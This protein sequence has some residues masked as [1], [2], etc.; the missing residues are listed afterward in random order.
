MTI[1]Q[2]IPR[3]AYERLSYLLVTATISLLLLSCNHADDWQ[4][5]IH[6]GDS[7]VEARSILGSRTPCDFPLDACEAFPNS[8]IEVKYDGDQVSEIMVF[9]DS[10]EERW[11][12]YESP[13]IFGITMRDG[14]P[15]LLDKLGEPTV[16][17]PEGFAMFKWRRPPWFVEVFFD[18]G[19]TGEGK[20]M[21]ITLTNAV[22]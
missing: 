4:L 7:R 17:D 6:L 2:S 16:A 21:W 22:G 13:I 15:E 3:R 8:G 18:T 14:L 10:H 19:G 12:Q 5:P 1:H 9:R 20:I 11:I